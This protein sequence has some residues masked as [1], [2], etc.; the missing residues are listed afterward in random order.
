MGSD[1][2]MS[3]ELIFRGASE[4]A[5]LIRSGAVSA[6]EVLDAHLTHLGRCNPRLNAIVTLN[7]H[8]K[9]Q[10][11]EADRFLAQGG[12][13]GPLHGVPFTAKDTLQTAGL[14][15]TASYPPLAE[16]VPSSD[17]LVVE[18]LKHAGAILLGK[19]NAPPLAMDSV[20]DGP[21]FGRTSNPWNLNHTP[22]GSSGGEACAIAA[23]LSPFG[24]GS[25]IGGS[26]R[27]PAHFCGVFAIKPTEHR[28]PTLGHIPP[29]PD[30]PN[31]ARFMLALGPVA[32]SIGD[33]GLAL[34]VMA[35]PDPRDP[36]VPPVPF[37][38]ASPRKP[39]A[40]RIAWTDSFG[41]VPVD[42]EIC[43]ALR[44]LVEKLNSL[45]CR[46]E[47]NI[48]SGLDFTDVWNAYGQLA[49]FILM[50]PIPR[51][52]RLAF[53]L[54]ARTSFRDPVFKALAKKTALHP[55]DLFRA[56]ELRDRMIASIESFLAEYDAW[57][58]PTA[59]IV[60]PVHRET[61]LPG[62][63]FEVSGGRISELMANGGYTLPFNLTGHPAVVF[64]AGSTA[65]GLPIGLQLVGRRWRDE[66][67]L[68]VAETVAQVSGPF[69]RPPGF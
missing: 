35:G 9:T 31:T 28:V 37:R 21:I 20:T 49:A 17:A 68:A 63:T 65:L 61:K 5:E 67:L 19:T 58:C 30:Q 6:C 34:S 57:L 50:P 11:A 3:H 33:L 47:R 36:D 53:K 44:V 60:A 25:D 64:P 45:G 4:L 62:R 7:P 8:A 10:A 41:G 38:S 18:R 66:D 22:G 26:V 51:A 43:A 54:A 46:C 24:V 59:P 1:P 13:P 56:L 29:L 39:S 55:R 32:R 69:K 12:R 52:F 23:G 15:T 14:R 27:V 2:C 16:H 40:L 42:D 48:P